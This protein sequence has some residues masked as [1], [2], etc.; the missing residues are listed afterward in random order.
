MSPLLVVTDRFVDNRGWFSE[1]WN[2]KKF[3]SLGVGHSFCQD[4]HSFSRSAYTVRG[5]HFQK[6]PFA[7]AKLVRCLRGSIFDVAVDIR[8]KSPTFLQWVGVELS[9]EAGDQLYIPTG[10]AHGFMT[11]EDNTEVAYKVDAYYAAAADAGIVW[12]DV[13]IGIEWPI[14]KR[15][16]TLSDKDL[17]LPFAD[18]AALDFP[19]NG[20]PINTS[21]VVKRK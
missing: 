13:K 6:E 10:Y 11:L 14:G 16:P 17:S 15:K 21:A 20:I 18:Q 7:Q 1:S 9:A 8:P 2:Y 5:L 19:Y 4:N 12:N 3:Q